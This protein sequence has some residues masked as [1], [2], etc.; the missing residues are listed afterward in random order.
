MHEPVFPNGCA[1]CEVEV[2]PDTGVR[3]PSR[4]MPRRRRRPLHQSA[5]R[6]RPDAWRHRA[7]RGAGD[8]GAVLHRPDLRPAAVPARSWITACRAPHTLP[9]F[10]AEI[11]EVLS[12]TNPLGI[13]AGGEGGTTPA[14]GGDRQRHRRCAARLRHPRHPDAGDAVHDLAGDPGREGGVGWVRRESAVTHRQTRG[15]FSR[16][17]TRP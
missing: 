1:I 6:A 7:G 17:V 13:K 3:R 9:S 16:W 15:E 11:V 12:P 5:D 10:K 4:A 14:L 2:D 8:V